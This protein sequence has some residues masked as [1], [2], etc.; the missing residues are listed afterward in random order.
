VPSKPP[1]PHPTSSTKE[2]RWRLRRG[3]D[4]FYYYIPQPDEGDCGVKKSLRRASEGWRSGS[5][6]TRWR[7]TFPIFL[8]LML[9]SAGG[10]LLYHHPLAVRWRDTSLISGVGVEKDHE[11]SWLAG[12]EGGW[13]FFK[14]FKNR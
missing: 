9:A 6:T 3:D 10:L 14:N 12:D 8:L 13:K 11:G 5:S 2:E 1:P 4:N 7:T